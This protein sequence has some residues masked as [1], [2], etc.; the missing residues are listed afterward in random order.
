MPQRGDTKPARRFVGA[1]GSTVSVSSGAVLEFAV[2]F[3]GVARHG[4]ACEALQ[5]FRLCGGSRDEGKVGRLN[6]DGVEAGEDYE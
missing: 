6:A 2:D 5:G 1:A 4:F 3:Q